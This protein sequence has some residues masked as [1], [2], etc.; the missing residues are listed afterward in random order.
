MAGVTSAGTVL[1]S[2]EEQIDSMLLFWTRVKENPSTMVDSG[3]MAENPRLIEFTCKAFWRLMEAGTQSFTDLNVI[4]DK[5][6][7]DNELLGPL[8]S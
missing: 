7:L 6:E 5:I 4:I 1:K 2:Y 3:D 8:K